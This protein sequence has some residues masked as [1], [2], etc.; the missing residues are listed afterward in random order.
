MKHESKREKE[1]KI[2]KYWI[3]PAHLKMYRKKKSYYT[4]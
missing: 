4:S 1:K 3:F 2:I